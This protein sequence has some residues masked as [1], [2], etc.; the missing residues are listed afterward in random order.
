MYYKYVAKIVDM[1]DRK[2]K[3]SAKPEQVSLHTLREQTTTVTSSFIEA[4]KKRHVF[5]NARGREVHG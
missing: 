5:L 1:I 3:S 2:V 4:R